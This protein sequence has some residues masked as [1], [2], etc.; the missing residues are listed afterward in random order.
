M[1]RVFLTLITIFTALLTLSAENPDT[2]KVKGSGVEATEIR[3]IS[4]FTAI[5][6][7]SAID[8][9]IVQ[10]ND[11]KVEVK[12]DS[13]VIDFVKTAVKDKHLIIGYTESLSFAKN[14]KMVGT[15]VYVTLPDISGVR[16]SAASDV[17]LKS[18]ITADKLLISGSSAA[19][20]DLGTYDIECNELRILASSSS[21][22]EGGVFNCKGK[23]S[24]E[25]SSASDI[26]SYIV[27]DV[28]KISSSSASDVDV[29]G[30]VN[31]LKTNVSSG[32]KIDAAQMKSIAVSANASSGSS[33]VVNAVES[34]DASASSGASIYYIG[35]PKEISRS[36][37]S[38]GSVRPKK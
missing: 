8:L 25:A 38:G 21:D 11:F 35:S 22:I 37:S 20:F 16:A 17:Y 5:S 33:I 30:S 3:N 6:V 23:V 13:N 32:S 34:L 10:G 12:A 19:D 36:V 2:R 9:Y 27:A 1:K 31:V 4:G 15:K 7:G 26:E 28:I 18:N 14:T 29:A 24:I